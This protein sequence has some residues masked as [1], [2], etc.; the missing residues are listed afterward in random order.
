MACPVSDSWSHSSAKCR[1]N[2]PKNVLRALGL[3]CGTSPRVCMASVLRIL[4]AFLHK[5]YS[6]P[7]YIKRFARRLALFLAFLG[8]RFSVWLRS[9]HGESG[10]IRRKSKRTEPP[11]PCT[12]ARSRTVSWDSA[13]LRENIVACSTVPTSVSV[14]SLQDPD[15]GTRQPATATPLRDV[16]LPPGLD[17][18]TADHVP[19]VTSSSDGRIPANLSSTNLSVHRSAS[20]G[21]NII[22]HPLEPF[23]TPADQ[24]LQCEL[25]QGQDAS[26]SRERQFRS[27]PT[28]Y[29]C[30]YPHPD[31][32][33]GNIS[34]HT[35]ADDGIIPTVSP[36]IPPSLTS[37][38]LDVHNSTTELLPAGS[39][40]NS[41][42]LVNNSYVTAPYPLIAH[43]ST[44]AEEPSQL[45]PPASHG[46][47]D[48]QW[49]EDDVLRPITS[50]QVSRYT[51]GIT[52]QVNC[53]ILVL[54]T[55]TCWQT[56]REDI[57]H[58]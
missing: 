1:I 4:L 49:R 38:V 21:H 15:R 8:P 43:F 5:L 54:H 35:H 53:T 32:E 3:L 10:T 41:Q 26:Q 12:T 28:D 42:R 48:H 2:K 13:G 30:Q 58:D 24:L 55:Y 17:S 23:H 22:R 46:M 18:F 20:D 16:I 50:E 25:G 47:S 14:P 44:A 11:S 45:L 7:N 39:S 6:S 36:T 34:S 56:Q 31:M 19:C 29:P 37:V 40:T 51:K 9:W 33:V 52:M 57:V 27:S